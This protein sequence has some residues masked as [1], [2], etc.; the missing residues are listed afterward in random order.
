MLLCLLQQDR[1]QCKCS[2]LV[3]SLLILFLLLVISLTFAE[4]YLLLQVRRDVLP[5]A[6]GIVP[7]LGTSER[8]AA[9]NAADVAEERDEAAKGITARLAVEARFK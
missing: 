7:Y 8:V 2:E 3:N 6:P 9:L 1:S 5:V 4:S